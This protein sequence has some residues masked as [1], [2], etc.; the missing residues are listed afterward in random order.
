MDVDENVSNLDMI[1]MDDGSDENSCSFFGAKQ[2]ELTHKDVN[3][4]RLAAEIHKQIESESILKLFEQKIKCKEDKMK[5]KRTKIQKPPSQ[6]VNAQRE[7][8]FKPMASADE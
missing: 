5:A 6:R 1:S 7:K 4:Q 8:E 3:A 2:I